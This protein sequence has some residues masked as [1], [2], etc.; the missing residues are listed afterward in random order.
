M[1]ILQRYLNRSTFIVWEMKRNVS[2][3]RLIVGTRSSGPPA[4]QPVSCLTHLSADLC[5]LVEGTYT[6]RLLFV[7][8]SVMCEFTQD[9]WKM[10]R[11]I[12]EKGVFVVRERTGKDFSKY[13]APG[14]IL[15]GSKWWPLPRH[16]M[17]SSHF[18]HKERTPVQISLQYR[19][20]C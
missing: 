10:Y 1:T 5:H 14:S 20:W 8:V 19:Y 6:I 12:L 15:S 7:S 9:S 13:G 16:V 17:M 11:Y 18:S 3:V 2:V 4:N